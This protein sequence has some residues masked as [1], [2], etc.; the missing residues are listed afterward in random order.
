M[1]STSSHSSPSAPDQLS[2]S[3][4]QPLSS[5]RLALKIAAILIL[6][7][8]LLIPL[9]MVQ[10]I[11]AERQRLQS[12]VE[13]S[14][15]E[16][17]AGEQQLVGP[18]L[19][20]PYQLRAEPPTPAMRGG[21]RSNELT[22]LKVIVPKT[23]HYDA[24]IKVEPR[25]KGIYRALVYRQRAT[26]KA[27]FVLPPGF[28]ISAGNETKARHVVVGEPYIVVAVS[29]ARGFVRVPALRW[30]GNMANVESGTRVPNW[31]SGV[32]AR[33][34]IQD[35]PFRADAPRGGDGSADPVSEHQLEMNVDLLGT[36]ALRLAPLAEA[37][38]AQVRADWPHPSFSG[39]WLPIEKTI[40]DDGFVARWE[41]NRLANT[42]VASFGDA[43]LMPQRLP[44]LERIDIGMVEP[45]SIYL[46]VERAI[47]YGVLFIAL[48]FIAFFV[49]E[50][51]KGLAIHPLQYGFVGLALCVF[52]LL[53]LSLSEHLPF[54]RAYVVATCGCV[55]IIGYY[56][57][58]VLRSTRRAIGFVVGMLVLFT[59]L[60]AVLQAED[61]ALLMGSVL[62]FV[63]LAAVMVATRRVDWYAI[64]ASGKDVPADRREA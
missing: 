12:Q 51:L 20:V 49:F 58:A 11:V 27:Q 36:R 40:R 61:L 62:V 23:L 30:N 6:T 9:S 45:L 25:Q 7:L 22:L 43:S 4:R 52:F 28:G 38:S 21:L 48:T 60:F 41:V 8:L 47:K 63:S 37:M 17:A 34:A 13:A 35:V 64:S 54:A 29:D 59:V 14:I 55:G 31:P 18:I 53:L 44:A 15:A 5:L 46:L 42:N 16:S 10:G 26:I 56:L 33:V 1:A 57:A 3:A 19:V 32:H 2:G 24:D 39:R 50:S